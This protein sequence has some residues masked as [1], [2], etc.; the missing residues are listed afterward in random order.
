MLGFVS[1][2]IVGVY[3]DFLACAYSCQLCRRTL[4][5]SMKLVKSAFHDVAYQVGQVVHSDC[6]FINVLTFFTGVSRPVSV[7]VS[8]VVCHGNHCITV[9]ALGVRLLVAEV[10]YTPPSPSAPL[11]P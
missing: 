8:K 3:M 2:G 4:L 5:A 9:V 6:C 1:R 10:I 11:S 7:T